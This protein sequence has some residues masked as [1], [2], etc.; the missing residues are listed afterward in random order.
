MKTRIVLIVSIFLNAG[1]A[2][3]FLVAKRPADKTTG[4]TSDALTKTVTRKSSAGRP[5][6]TVIVPGKDLNWSSVES[7]DYKQYIANMRAAGVP[8]ET[9]RDIIIADV[10]KLYAGKIAALRPSPSDFKFWKTYDREARNAERERGQK[11]R[12]LQQEKR[13]LIKEL[14][15][16]D[17]EAE[18]ARQNGERDRDALRYGFLSPEKQEQLKS[19]REKFRDQE[20]A[21][22]ANGGGFTPENRA[23]FT[24][25]RA[26]QEAEMAAL[27]TPAE[28]EEYQLRSSHTARNMRENMTSFQPTEQEFREIFKLQKTFDDQYGMMRGG[29]GDDTLRQS[30]EQ[31]QQAL[32][33]QLKALLGDQR[34]KDY[35]LAQDEHYRDIYDFAQNN[36][37]TTDTAQK[38]YEVRAAAEAER[39][40]IQNDRSIP[41]D[42]RQAQ[43]AALA[44][45][46]KQ[47]LGTFLGPDTFN[48]YQ[49]GDGRWINRLDS[50]SDGR[51]SGR[52]GP[53]RG[54]GGGGR[55]GGRRG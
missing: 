17:L 53:G 39:Q 44:T 47:A 14:L 4:D 45:Q 43:L 31:A 3:A 13:E 11:E 7:D 46:T 2:A 20:R 30:R 18:I 49:Q 33:E 28:F 8:E 1:L 54:P 21:I 37:L 55:P 12:E 36:N 27:L 16:V 9:I 23:K 51:G 48:T 35:T 38:I 42:Q 29:G 34:F 25:L 22:F 32:E 10:N 15:G 41:A 40:R 6:R 19:L 26:Q 24:A 50:S 52:G 5:A